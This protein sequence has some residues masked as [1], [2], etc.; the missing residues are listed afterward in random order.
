MPLW[1]PAMLA[2][3]A[4]TPNRLSA[5]RVRLGLGHRH[6]LGAIEAVGDPRRSPKGAVDALEEALTSGGRLER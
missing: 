6:F 1:P 2:E 4:A 5:A 3:A